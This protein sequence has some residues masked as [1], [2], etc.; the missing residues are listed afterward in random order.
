[1]N[2]S[3]T[4]APWKVSKRGD[5]VTAG[6][7]MLGGMVS[8]CTVTDSA[9]ARLIAAAPDLLA[10]LSDFIRARGD[11]LETSDPVWVMRARAALA[12]AEAA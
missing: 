2:Q 10:V 5:Q 6:T 7:N 8:V 12:K 11:E 1:M 9:N 4:P 3:H